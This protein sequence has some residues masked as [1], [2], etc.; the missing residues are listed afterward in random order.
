[1]SGSSTSNNTI[2]QQQNQQSGKPNGNVEA[3]RE[4][5]VELLLEKITTNKN[6]STR[7]SAFDSLK[8]IVTELGNGNNNGSGSGSEKLSGALMKRIVAA[9]IECLSDSHFKVISAC[10]D[11]LIAIM[12]FDSS[13]ILPKLDLLMFKVLNNLIDTKDVVSSRANFLVNLISKVFPSEKLIE[14]I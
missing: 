10:L 8:E 12:S 11:S 13:Y 6:W 1:M 7:A 3:W 14:P 2:E 5:D 4:D 9:H